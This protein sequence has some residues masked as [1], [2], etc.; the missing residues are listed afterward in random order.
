M[1]KV[2][3]LV[4]SIYN[5]LFFSIITYLYNVALIPY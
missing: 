3:L 2:E 1:D 4:E 5:M